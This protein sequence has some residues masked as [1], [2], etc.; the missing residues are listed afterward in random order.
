MVVDL[1]KADCNMTSLKSII[2]FVIR[3]VILLSVGLYLTIS[4]SG[5]FHRFNQTPHNYSDLSTDELI[6]GMLVEGDITL[7]Y[8]KLVRGT[9]PKDSDKTLGY[10]YLILD[11]EKHFIG[12]YTPSNDLN[13]SLTRQTEQSYDYFS[14]ETSSMPD[15]VHFKGI[16][17][18]MDSSVSAIYRSNIRDR[19]SYTS[20]EIDKSF[21]EVFINTEPPTKNTFYLVIGIISIVVALINSMVFIRR[22]IRGR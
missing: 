22:M 19:F 12:L 20:D 13:Y 18:K 5:E 21:S 11:S 8:G 4:I 7:N 6:P 10:Y 2:L 17:Q 14:G 15:A 9:D 16:V 1:G 3:I